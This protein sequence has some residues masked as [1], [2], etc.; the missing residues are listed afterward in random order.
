VLDRAFEGVRAALG[1]EVPWPA[2]R[3]SADRARLAM[4]LV[5]GAT[6]GGVLAADEHLLD[7]LLDRDLALTEDLVRRRLAPLEDLPQPSRERLR[8]TLEA[9]L[10]HQ[11]EVRPIADALHVHVQTVRYR[12]SQLRELVPHVFEDPSQRLELELALRASSRAARPGE[13]ATG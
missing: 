7:L 4:A 11:G 13:T 6:D 5:G 1:P 10:A 2:A 3:R 9:W 12:I 8:E